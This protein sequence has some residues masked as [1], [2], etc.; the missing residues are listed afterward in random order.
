MA[1]GFAVSPPTRPSLE[2]QGSTS[3][4]LED[5]WVLDVHYKPVVQ[6][7]LGSGL[8]PSNIH[9]GIDIYF[10]CSV[11]SNPPVS[12][13]SWTF[14]GRDLHTDGSRGII[15]SN[16]SLALRSVN[17]TNSGFYACH[18]ANSEGEAESNRLRLRVLHSPVC[19]S[20]HRQ[21][22]HSVAKH[23]TVE[24]ECD[25]E[26]DPNNVTFSWTFH[27]AHRS[28]PLSPNASFSTPPGAPLR[29]V[30][31]Y[32][33]R[34]DADY[35]TLYCRAR[36][37]VGD[38]LEPCIFQIHPVGPPVTPYNCSV[39]EV[40]SEG[41][42]VVCQ[43][44]GA[45]QQQ[46]FLLELQDGQNTPIVTNFTSGQPSFRVHSLRPATRYQMALY[47]I[48]ANGRSEPVHLTVFTLP[49]GRGL[50]SKEDTEWSLGSTTLWAAALSA[51]AAFLIVFIALTLGKFRRKI[52]FN[53]AQNVWNRNE[54]CWDASGFGF[55]LQNAEVENGGAAGKQRFSAA[56]GLPGPL[57]KRVAERGKHVRQG[58]S[59][60]KG[61]RENAAVLAMRL[62]VIR[63]ASGHLKLRD[64]DVRPVKPVAVG[65]AS[66]GT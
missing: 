1:Q 28:A 60:G 40:T 41:V 11:R 23:D 21:H 46:T 45:G 44:S 33:P 49:V 20:G 37:A 3:A 7:R 52:L 26:A 63:L 42:H 6:L 10:E 34:S 66:R 14:D 54:S 22:S 12:E 55:A 47:G 38:S 27:Q 18:A 58:D 36:N 51:V 35:G 59:C 65:K 16:Q 53:R 57:C 48:N 32:T 19:Q 64:S 17:R 62:R 61:E 50:V 30:L 15:V 8:S 39:E 29:S 43:R 31:R 24:V 5:S 25:V 56:W 9:E 13:V 4:P 2:L